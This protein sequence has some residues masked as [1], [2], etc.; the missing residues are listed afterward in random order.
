M[1]KVLAFV[2]CIPFLPGLIILWAI[3]EIMDSFGFFNLK[4]KE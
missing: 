3:M 1:K 4:D 2:I